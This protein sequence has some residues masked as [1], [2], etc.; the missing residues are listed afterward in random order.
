MLIFLFLFSILLPDRIEFVFQLYND[1][2]TGNEYVPINNQSE[3]N[4]EYSIKLD[5]IYNIEDETLNP[6][7]KGKKIYK[8]EDNKKFKKFFIDYDFNEKLN[9]N[10]NIV[11]DFKAKIK[12]HNNSSERV[13]SGSQTL[14]CSLWDCFL[15]NPSFCAAFSKE[16]IKAKT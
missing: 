5:D 12:S 13:Y 8:D 9:D 2:E 11:I 4:I 3:I 1:S 10:M 7:R 6:I 14:H 15:E 16:F